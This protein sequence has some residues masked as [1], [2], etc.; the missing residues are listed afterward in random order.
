MTNVVQLTDHDVCLGASLID[1]HAFRREK[2][3]LE[4]GMR[5]CYLVKKCALKTHFAGVMISEAPMMSYNSQQT[6]L[7]GARYWSFIVGRRE[8][9]LVTSHLGQCSGELVARKHVFVHVKWRFIELVD[10]WA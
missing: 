3:V 1:R 2:V 5:I 6:D 4:C 7:C 8:I 10:F 9:W